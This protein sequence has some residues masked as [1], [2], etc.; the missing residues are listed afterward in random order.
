MRR[1]RRLAFVRLAIGVLCACALA[2]CTLPQRTLG[3]EMR[4]QS[5]FQ[6]QWKRYQK[7]EDF[8]ALVIAGD[9]EGVYVSGF[10]YEMAS[11]D[12]AVRAALDLCE[13]RRTDR[14]IVAP[15]RTV[16]IGMVTRSDPDLFKA[17][18]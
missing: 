6:Q 13:Q 18:D 17:K 8:K 7:L 12:E 4:E 5:R 11:T 15:C 2:A 9:V 3:I 10:S 14:R 16:A 1:E